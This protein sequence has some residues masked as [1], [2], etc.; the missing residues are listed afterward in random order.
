MAKVSFVGFQEKVEIPQ[1]FELLEITEEI[2]TSLH[3]DQLFSLLSEPAKISEWFYQVTSFDSRP[4]GKVNFIGINNA[5]AQAVCTSFVLG[6][7]ISL[8]AD[9]FGNFSAKVVK[10]SGKN[11]IN[12]HFAIL[13]DDA[14]SKSKEIL[15]LIDRLRALLS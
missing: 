2:P 15:F 10:G 14:E 7:E 13:T 11:S 6:K 9:L 8:I 4:G 5:S 3:K 1:G 12:L